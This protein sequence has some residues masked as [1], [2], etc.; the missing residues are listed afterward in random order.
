MK[1]MKEIE[2]SEKIKAPAAKHIEKPKDK[3]QKPKK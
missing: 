2:K 1:Y 3:K